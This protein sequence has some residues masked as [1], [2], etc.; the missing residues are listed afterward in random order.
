MKSSGESARFLDGP[1]SHAKL[2]RV[3]KSKSHL[4]RIAI[5]LAPKAGDAALENDLIRHA[6]GHG[7]SYTHRP[8]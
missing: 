1:P 7:T 6:S 4:I 8:R 5:R 3:Q 2:T